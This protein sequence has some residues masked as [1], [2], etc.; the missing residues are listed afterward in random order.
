MFL[1]PLTLGEG[2]PDIVLHAQRL[3]EATE[4]RLLVG[5]VTMTLEISVME[6]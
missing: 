3:I 6:W 5:T 4:P 2:A 1:W